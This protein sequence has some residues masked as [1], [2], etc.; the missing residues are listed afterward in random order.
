MQNESVKELEFKNANQ[1]RKCIAKE[2]EL[3]GNENENE[4]P[5]GARIPGLYKP[6]L[7]SVQWREPVKLSSLRSVTPSYQSHLIVLIPF[8]ILQGI[9]QR[10]ALWV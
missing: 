9:P 4:D 1:K 2:F 5:S 10:P 3:E 6:R 7:T 8:L